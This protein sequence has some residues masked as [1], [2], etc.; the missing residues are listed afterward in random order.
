MDERVL[1]RFEYDENR[2]NPEINERKK[3]DRAQFEPVMDGTAILRLGRQ[4]RLADRR[5]AE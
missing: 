2:V 5:A 4:N 1:P 3:L